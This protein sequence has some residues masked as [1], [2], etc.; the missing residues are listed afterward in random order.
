M[1][2]LVL[3]D[4][5]AVAHRAFHAIPKENFKRQGQVINAVYGF[6]SMLVSAVA[7]LKP[8]Y[9]IACFDSQGQTFRHEKFIGYQSKRPETLRELTS[10]IE[11]IKRSLKQADI[12]VLEK[13]GFEADDIIGTILKK[14][15]VK[16]QKSKIKEAIVITGDKDLMQLVTDKAKLYFMKKGVSEVE[17]VGPKE[18]K[19]KL[20]VRPDQV[21]DYKAL[22]GDSSDNYPGVKG[23]GPKTAA[24]LL[25]EF[26][27]LSNIFLQVDKIS[28]EVR[29]RLERS[30]ES[31]VI[32]QELARIVTSVS[33]EFSRR[34]SRWGKSKLLKLK[35]VLEIL[36]FPSLVKRVDNAGDLA[37]KEKQL[38]LI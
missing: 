8:D 28:T 7:E 33:I 13:S 14:L 32:S 22:M 31:A 36:R 23:I 12:P 25:E 4:S 26:D 10:Q 9:L 27:N 11:L 37:K 19:E 38:Q 5:H 1:S 15:K 6:F 24:K 18:V 3:I 30:K 2:K 35:T 34:K 29:N 17:L 21:V 16:S 20:G